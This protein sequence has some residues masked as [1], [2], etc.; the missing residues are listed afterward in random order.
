MAAIG[1]YGV[2]AYYVTRR[3]QEIGVRVALGATGA[4]VMRS[5]VGR[6]LLLVTIGLAIG[7]PASAAVTRLLRAQLFEVAPN[8]AVTYTGVI[9]LLL[10]IGAV[11]CLVPAR[12]AVRIDPVVALKAE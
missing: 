7:I 5:V 10:V 1:L 9:A 8:D 11:A 12:R 2:L 4:N 3:T 6:G